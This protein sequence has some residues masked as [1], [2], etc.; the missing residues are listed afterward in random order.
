MSESMATVIRQDCSRR[1]SPD[2]RRRWDEHRSSPA[3]ASLST[4]CRTQVC[5]RRAVDSAVERS[6]PSRDLRERRPPP[7]DA[8]SPKGCRLVQDLLAIDRHATRS[9]GSGGRTG[10]TSSA[11]AAL[12]LAGSSTNGSWPDSSNQTSSFEGAVSLSK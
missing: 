5:L 4:E 9:G 1:R 3:T 11:I 8:Y 10:R 6:A 12:N 7:R 2:Q